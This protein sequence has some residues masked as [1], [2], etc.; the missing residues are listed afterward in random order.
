M[1]NVFLKYM[2]EREGKSETEQETNFPQGSVITISR[3]YG[4]PGKR[5]GEHLTK[6]LRTLVQPLSDLLSLYVIQFR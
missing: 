4:C 5:I 1:D 2:S 3:E 6:G